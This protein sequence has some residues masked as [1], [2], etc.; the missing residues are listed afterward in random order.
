MASYDAGFFVEPPSDMVT[1][2]IITRRISQRWP[3]HII[4]NLFMDGGDVT[5]II[6]VRQDLLALGDDGI[7][8]GFF[9]NP[10]NRRD[11]EDGITPINP[12]WL[13]GRYRWW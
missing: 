4:G 11:D 5:P 7:P 2:G 10:F 8:G 9:S 12:E 3:A 6:R 1:A 13:V